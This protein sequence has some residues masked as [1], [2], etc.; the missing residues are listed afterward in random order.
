MPAWPGGELASC[1][2]LMLLQVS[3]ADFG[4]QAE[5]RENGRGAWGW[6]EGEMR[7]PRAG[8]GE[9]LPL[10]KGDFQ[11]SPTNA[12]GRTPTVPAYCVLFARLVSVWVEVLCFWFFFLLE[13]LQGNLRD[14]KEQ[15]R[16]AGLLKS[17]SMFTFV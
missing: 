10:P 14:R 8:G 15:P 6:G 4:T 1:S 17:M 5:R 9:A 12:D 7:S 3:G 2:R 11:G 16:G 13:M